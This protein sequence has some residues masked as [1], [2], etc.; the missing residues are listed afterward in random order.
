MCTLQFVIVSALSVL[1][2]DRADLIL[3]HGKPHSAQAKAF[4]CQMPP[5][6]STS[7]SQTPPLGGFYAGEVPRKAQAA[8]K[9]LTFDV[10]RQPT[11][12]PDDGRRRPTSLP[13]TAR[14]KPHHPPH[15]TPPTPCKPPHFVRPVPPPPP[16]GVGGGLHHKTVP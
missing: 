3:V 13:D 12:L 4:F 2:D 1:H 9:S 5:D 15:T 10:Q 7:P 6:A 16:R 8:K 14:R 11:F